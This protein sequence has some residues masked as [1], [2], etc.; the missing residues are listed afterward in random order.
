MPQVA[1]PEEVFA[2][3]RY[4]AAAKQNAN[5]L[6][7]PA[8]AAGLGGPEV[9]F[10]GGA[11]PTE[12]TFVGAG[13]TGGP[14]EFW[15]VLTDPVVVTTLDRKRRELNASMER[16]KLPAL[17]IYSAETPYAIIRTVE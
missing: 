4:K 15:A 16:A 14:Y 1:T 7:V 9:A 11:A 13:Y 6:G 12:M 17:S 3:A 10:L 5:I 2:A 8:P